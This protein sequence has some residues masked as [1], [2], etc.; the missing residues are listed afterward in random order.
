MRFGQKNI[1]I[2]ALATYL[3]ALNLGYLHHSFDHHLDDAF[4]FTDVLDEGLQLASEDDGMLCKLCDFFQ[5]QEVFFSENNEV[6]FDI[7]PDRSIARTYRFTFH[8]SVFEKSLRG[9]PSLG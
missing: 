4:V 1:R 2:Y 6:W 3:L 9:P 7:R 5:N 8:S